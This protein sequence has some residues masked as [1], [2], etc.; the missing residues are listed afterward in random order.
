MYNP[1][2]QK[3]WFITIALI[4]GITAG[5]FSVYQARSL[6]D[7][8]VELR[9]ENKSLQNDLEKTKDDLQMTRNENEVLSEELQ[10]AEERNSDFEE[11]IEDITDT[12]GDISRFT[13]VDP[14]LL[15]KYSRVFFL[16]ENYTPSDL[17]KIDEEYVYDDD[18]E[19]FHDD[20][21]DFLEEMIEDAEDDDINLKIIS[22]YRSFQTQLSLNNNY[23]VTYGAG[24]ANEF[25]AEQ[26]YSEHQLGTAVDFTTPELGINFERIDDT[27][28]Y[29]WL[30]DNAHE[31]GFVLSYPEGNQYYQYEPWHWRFIGV[32]L[33]EDLEDDDAFFYDWEQRKIDEYRGEIFEG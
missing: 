17:E 18:T 23:T 30:I 9:N 1:S 26:G 14:E 4:I 8:L 21:Y 6:T 28:A 11:Q 12:V 2:T 24:T 5:G 27:D 33:A 31:Y 7:N 32:D 29:N 10:M 3:H 22:A 15:K 19:Y 13:S 16:S 20:A 25:S